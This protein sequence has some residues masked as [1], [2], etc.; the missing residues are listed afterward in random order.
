VS[1][2]EVLKDRVL[3]TIVVL[4]AR[5]ETVVSV[6]N[7]PEWQVTYAL[8]SLAREGRIFYARGFWRHKTGPVTARRRV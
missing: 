6:V 8:R 2:F 5:P 3:R 1:S 7:A 4:P